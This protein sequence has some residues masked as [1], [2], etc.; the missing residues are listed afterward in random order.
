MFSKDNTEQNNE[1]I[2]VSFIYIEIMPDR[3]IAVQMS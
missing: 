3:A 1:Y 2:I